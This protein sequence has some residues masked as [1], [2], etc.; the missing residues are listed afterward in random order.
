MTEL[1]RV[2]ERMNK[3]LIHSFMHLAQKPMKK[4][5]ECEGLE[6]CNA[7]DEGDLL[8]EENRQFIERLKRAKYF[9]QW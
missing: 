4:L 8:L 3:V 5:S 9:W 1:E 2:Q 6:Y 7:P